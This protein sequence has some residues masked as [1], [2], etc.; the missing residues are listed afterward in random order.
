MA[1]AHLAAPPSSRAAAPEALERALARVV[2]DG[3]Y[4]TDLPT[5]ESPS[6]PAFSSV[7][8]PIAAL[9]LRVLGVA[10]LVALLLTAVLMVQRSIRA[11]RLAHPDPAA[12]HARATAPPPTP[13]VDDLDAR[14]RSGDLDAAIHDL[15]H[16]VLAWLTAS[17][18]ALRP[19]SLTSREL[20]AAAGLPAP[21]TAAL[22][23]L[24]DT[25]ERAIFAGRP[26]APADWDRCRAAYARLETSLG[27]RP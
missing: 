21:A 9:L 8:L 17:E 24:V 18:P 15:L 1:L 13:R 7:G 4:Q 25:V 19:A 12:G 3:A 20:L 22:A 26:A 6:P 23:E 11:R 5:P 10:V 16:R 27:S 14:A 2:A